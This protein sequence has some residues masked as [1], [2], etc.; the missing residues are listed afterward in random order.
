MHRL[1]GLL[2]M[3]SA[4]IA[5]A[6]PDLAVAVNPPLRWAGADS[7]AGSVY[8][9]VT[10]HSAIRFNVARYDYSAIPVLF[11]LAEDG[12]SLVDGR[13]LDGGISW[14]HFSDKLHDGFFIEFGALVRKQDTRVEDD[15]ASTFRLDTDT[16][17]IAARAM[18]G[19]SWKAADPV[20]IALSLGLSG[21]Y[22]MGTETH[23]DDPMT[24]TRMPTTVDVS[25]DALAPEGWLRL[26]VDFG[27]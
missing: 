10:K 11:W 26:G 27:K 6:S 24:S 2:I 17:T 23:S 3:C 14:M 13:I 21:G 19:Y 5:S 7:L 18:V 9:G 16:T 20:F 8:W 15:F 4:T 22:E 25:R 12:P 1:A